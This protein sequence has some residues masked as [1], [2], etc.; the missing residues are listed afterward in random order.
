MNIHIVFPFLGIYSSCCIC[1]LATTYA[2]KF[3]CHAFLSSYIC[4]F[5]S[6]KPRFPAQANLARISDQTAVSQCD[7]RR[8]VN[9]KLKSKKSAGGEIGPEYCWA[10]GRES[11]STDCRFPLFEWCA[12]LSNNV[13][14]TAEPAGKYSEQVLDMGLGC[15]LGHNCVCSEK[16]FVSE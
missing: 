7:H 11:R 10:L 3:F 9:A 8:M 16:S 15:S 1:F 6:E 2:M 5:L 12:F 13:L 4:H 14:V